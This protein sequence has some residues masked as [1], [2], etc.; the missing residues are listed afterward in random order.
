MCRR[1]SYSKATIQGVLALITAVVAG[2]IL[3]LTL[4]LGRAVI[5]PSGVLALKG[6]DAISLGWV[7]LSLVLLGK[8]KQNV[9]HLILLSVGFGLLRHVVHL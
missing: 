4:F 6:L 7:V 3:N 8:F 9:V 1:V 5:F 2:A